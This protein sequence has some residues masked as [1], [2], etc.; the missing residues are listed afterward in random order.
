MIKLIFCTDGI[1]PHQV[2]GMQRH[3]RLLI[4]ELVRSHDITEIIVIHPHQE[5]LFHH[6][7]IREE[8]LAPVNRNKNYIRE[9]YRY[10]K[11]VAQ[12]LDRYPD[13]LIYA[14]GL[15]VWYNIRKYTPRLIENPHGLEPFQALG[16]KEK[17]IA[18]PFRIIFRYIWKHAAKVVSLGGELTGILK[19]NINDK[20][21]IVELANA[22]N[23][24]E[25]TTGVGRTFSEKTTV[26][27]LSRFASNKG[28]HILMAAIRWLNENGYAE[29][30]SF[31][32]GGKGPLWEFYKSQNNFTN[33]TFLGFVADEELPS[34]FLRSDVFVLP[35]LFEGM[36]TAI[37]EAMSFHL[38][39]IATRTGAI[40][41]LVS[42]EN[43]Y[44]I[45]RNDVMALADAC[46]KFIALDESEKSAMGEQS[47]LKVSR[48]FTWQVVAVRHVELFLQMQKNIGK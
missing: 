21:K 27:F 32:L 31:L 39:V 28:I 19:Q 22:T 46:L 30:F 11:S 17:L 45:P 36:P 5:S 24:P 3:S 44:L 13:Y 48:N 6:P 40:E 47:Y 1:F 18:I 8:K 33:V 23:L 10:S 7:K 34:V 26:F 41:L 42:E 29:K 37:L 38:P 14:Q 2:G 9:C 25:T 20:S 15:T 35:T 4:E 12:V 16:I 43:G